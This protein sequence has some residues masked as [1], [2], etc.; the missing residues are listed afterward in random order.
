MQRYVS[1]KISLVC[2][3]LIGF[4]CTQQVLAHDRAGGLTATSGPGATDFY[5]ITCSNDPATGTVTDRLFFKIRDITEGG[6][7]VG[8]TVVKADAPANQAATTT[9]DLVGGTDPAYSPDSQIKGGNGIYNVTVWHTGVASD[10]SYSFAYHCEN[11]T[12]HTGTT[13]TRVSNQ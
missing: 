9:V 2:A 13:I 1:K 11:G 8:M 7:L 6:N 5:T 10:E 12:T 4:G 3:M